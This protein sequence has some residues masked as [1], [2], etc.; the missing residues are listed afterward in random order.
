MD[1]HEQN[2]PIGT[3]AKL[4]GAKKTPL[5][6]T[7]PAASV[8]SDR[9]EPKIGQQ[10]VVNTIT[11]NITILQKDIDELTEPAYATHT[12]KLHQCDLEWIKDAAHNLSKESARGKVAQ[13][14]I[15]RLSLRLFAKL[16]QNDKEAM[17]RLIGKIK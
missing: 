4:M 12:F 10:E 7:K 13:T 11:C 16:L 3:F 1:N 2:K 6:G 14:D 17:L 5:E 8:I 15:V 9:R